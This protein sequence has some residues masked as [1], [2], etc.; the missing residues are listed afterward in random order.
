MFVRS[1]GDRLKVGS[2]LKS[3]LSDYE[4][5]RRTD[6]PRATVQ[7]WRRDGF[8]SR[9]ASWR[10]P[11]GWRPGDERKYAYLLGV[12]L[13]DGHIVRTGPHGWRLS[14][15]MDSA[16]PR[17]LSETEGA[18][19][20][21]CPGVRVCVNPRR[22][23]VVIQASSP[24][25][26]AAFPQHGPG[27]KHERRIELEGWQSEIT[28]QHPERLL[29]GLIHSDGC[30]TVNRFGMTLKGGRVKNYAYP[31]YFFTNASAD[32]RRIFC[33]HCELLGIRWSRSNPR[34]IS[35]AHRDSVAALDEFIGPKR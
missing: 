4:I 11:Q 19:R 22:G 16:Y 15:Y 14:V 34:N 21:V 2:L 24:V 7:K 18:I 23:S 31:R 33:E 5:A 1:H 8:P 26:P 27:R 35:V 32:I 20:A 3:G 6:V 28:H 9:D 30:R 12:Y 13:G 25:W 29:R 10:V 17:I